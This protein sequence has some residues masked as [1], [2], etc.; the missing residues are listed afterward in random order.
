MRDL[1]VVG[2]GPV[3]LAAALYARR[4]GLEVTVFEPREGPID[5]AC[6]EGLMPGALA[7]LADLGVDPEGHPLR[8][9]R[10]VARD[11]WTQ[12]D[13]LAGPGRGV[14]RTTLHAALLDAARSAD[15]WIE[16]RAVDAI[17]QHEDFVKVADLRA[18]YIIAADGLHSP[19]RRMLGLDASEGPRRLDPRRFGQRRHA[20]VSPWSD[21]VEVHWS[22]GAEAY[23][24]PVAPSVVGVALLTSTRAGFDALL[25]G[26]P[27]LQDRLGG[28]SMSKVRGAGPLRQRSKRRVAG[29]VLLAGDASGYVDA[30]TGE[31]IS[32]GLT[33]AHAAVAAIVS[34]R[35][36]AYEGAWRR[37][38]WRYRWLTTALVQAS[39]VPPVRARL[40]PAAA[41]LPR[42]FSAAVNELAGGVPG[43]PSGDCSA[44]RGRQSP[45]RA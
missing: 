17:R 8:G 43:T 35:P 40:V 27:E 39:R 7:A 20:E 29:R 3:G 44:A 26:F 42:V 38:T 9:I 37:L 6:G 30:L 13:F 4:A 23:V 1:I 14:R 34:G 11:C 18:R 21:H 15:V 33:Q 45:R 5:K 22:V 36:Q 25:Q 12:A 28:V 2:G 31:G 24:T 16:P 19:V 10:Y 41:M 32:I